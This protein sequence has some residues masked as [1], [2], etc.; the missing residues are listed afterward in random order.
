MNYRT[1]FAGLVV[2]AVGMFLVQGCTAQSGNPAVETP[3]GKSDFS[4]L[5]WSGGYMLGG[6]DSAA[7]GQNKD[8]NSTAA[9][10]TIEEGDIWKISGDFLYVLNQ[11]RGLQIISMID[12]DKPRLAATVPILGRPV[13]MYLRDG[14]AYVVVSDYF[15]CWVDGT[16]AFAR[17]FQGSQ[18]RI[19]D[20]RSPGA[21]KVVGGID[22]K[23]FVTDTRIVGEVMYLI[24]DRYSYYYYN[25]SDS[26][27]L[28]S[29]YSINIGDP[30]SVRLVDE[31]HFKRNA[32]YENHVNVTEN[33]IFLATPQWG[34]YGKDGTYHD[35]LKTGITYIDIHDPD[36]AIALGA[37][38][39]LKGYVS[40]RWQMDFT[41][42]VLRVL[43][44][45]RAW[46]NGYPMLFTFKV[47]DPFH[48]NPLSAWQ[49][50]LPAAETVKSTR[51]DGNRAYVVT[52][53]QKD[54]LFTV[55]L[56][57]PAAPKLGGEI[58]MSG[59]L[60]FM[61]PRG[62]FLVALGHDDQNGSNVLAVSLFDVKNIRTPTLLKRVTFGEEWGWTPGEKDDIQKVF[63]VLDDQKMILVPFQGWSQTSYRSV[64]GVQLIDFDT[65]SAGEPLVLRGMIS[66]DGWVERATPFKSRVV[67]FSNESFQVADVS[68]RDHPVLTAVLELARNSADFAAAGEVGVELSGDSYY[69]GWYYDAPGYSSGRLKLSVV[70][71]DDPNTPSP[72]S[73]A[74][75]AGYGGRVFTEGTS[76]FVVSTLYDQGAYKT[77]VV[78]Y[79]L[80][81]PQQLVKLG[82][83]EI[84][85]QSGSYG[86]Y[87]W[88]GMP[89]GGDS[90]VNPSP[91]VLAIMSGSSYVDEKAA[92]SGEPAGGL[93]IV[94]I[95][96]PA[97]MKVASATSF[98]FKSRSYLSQMKVAGSMVYMTYSVPVT[99]SGVYYEKYYLGRVDITDIRSP[100]VKPAVNVPGIFLGAS[101]DGRYIF[102]VENLQQAGCVAGGGVGV[103][104]SSTV[105]PKGCVYSGYYQAINTLAMIGDRAYLRDTMELYTPSS[106]SEWYWISNIVSEGDYAYYVLNKSWNEKNKYY[107]SSTL[108]TLDLRVARDIKV[109]GPQPL[110]VQNIGVRGVASGRLL[111]DFYGYAGGGMLM[112]NLKTPFMP[113]FEGSFGTQGYP[114]RVREGSGKLYLPSGYYGVQTV[115]L[116]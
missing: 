23:G 81:N 71:I 73:K 14:N 105:S 17:E 55:D 45:E 39:D 90:I 20:V 5:P 50:P 58:Q 99:D 8:T 59:W 19:V 22:L 13:E 111:L 77:R 43:A 63:R 75:V 102:T 28:T 116:K 106:Q 67:S 40:E 108:N 79:D 7:P 49:V 4:S 98:W 32:G 44:P 25:S 15:N 34:W 54:P 110:P 47:V 11:Y 61:E 12:V 18:L 91:G 35:D 104:D 57:D 96:K 92:A 103:G 85:I 78:A 36:G 29:V 38:F 74:D 6:E 66:H 42:G 60:D 88:W 52:Y 86:Y 113:V 70:P 33:A 95:S 37:S 1:I 62:D 3:E 89:G 93:W 87:G 84:P 46:G 65:G 94:D 26:E 101:S 27:D 10:R 56:T 115:E 30:A 114:V 2:L 97:Q 51:F 109:A 107:Q 41:D 53:L 16:A 76:A 9:P 82:T 24:S 68:D 21:P 83:L 112:Y 72:E 80:S 64:S 31:A 69:S 100:V 48:I